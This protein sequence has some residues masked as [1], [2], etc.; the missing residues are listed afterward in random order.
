[1][2]LWTETLRKNHEGREDYAVTLTRAVLSET[3]RTGGARAV[4]R[5]RSD[6]LPHSKFWFSLGE[7]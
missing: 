5:R 2:V 3:N 6:A 4:H 7:Y 1:M